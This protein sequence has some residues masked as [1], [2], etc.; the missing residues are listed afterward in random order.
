[1][2]ENLLVT[3]QYDLREIPG[4]ESWI[5]VSEISDGDSDDRKFYIKNINRER[6]FLRVAD[7]VHYD[8]KKNQH[9]YLKL[10]AASGGSVPEPVGFGLCGNGKSIYLQ[11]KWL[12]G[13]QATTKLGD[14]DAYRQYDLGTSAGL[15]LKFI[16]CCPIPTRRAVCWEAAQ[17]KRWQRAWD[18]YR[19]SYCKIPYDQ[20]IINLINNN[21]PLLADRPQRLLHGGFETDNVVISYEDSLSLIDLDNWQYGDPLYDLANVLTQSRHLGVP[22]AIGILDCYFCFEISDTDLRLMALYGAMNLIERAATQ[23]INL[24]ASFQRTAELIQLFIRDFHGCRNISP[25]WYKRMRNVS[26]KACLINDPSDAFE[27]AC[28]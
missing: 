10:I 13:Y 5:R 20:K 19:K 18:N 15:N 21:L 24:D 8:R 17:L 16:H 4:S 7:R 11:T 14:L 28:D 9:D 27:M 1:M 25:F 6:F 2:E 3:E 22:Y 12:Y 23:Q 26:G